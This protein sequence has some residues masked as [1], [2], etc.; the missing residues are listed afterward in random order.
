MDE[1]ALLQS[2]SARSSDFPVLIK[3]SLEDL[4]KH[5]EGVLQNSE[6]P[7]TKAHLKDCLRG[8]DLIL[9]PKK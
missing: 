2:T 6:D 9:N 8:I 7:V 5:I 1:A 3:A 4:A